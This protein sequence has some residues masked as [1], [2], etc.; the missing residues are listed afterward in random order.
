MDISAF[1]ALVSVIFAITF[2]VGLVVQT[3]AY[4][5]SL[6]T[7]RSDIVD[8]VWGMSFVFVGFF[9]IAFT[10]APSFSFA[11]ALLLVS[12]WGVRLSYHIGLRHF[13]K[14]TEDRRY[15]S[16]KEGWRF[17]QIRAYFQIFVLQAFLMSIIALPLVLH[18]NTG[19]TTALPLVCIGV[20]VWLLGFYFQVRGDFELSR[21]I[22]TKK[23]T[24]G[25]LKTGIWG[26]TRH[27]NYFGEMTMWWGIFI[28]T[29]SSFNLAY[30]I[31]AA[32][33]PILITL[34]LR[35]VSGVPMLEKYWE[36]KYQDEF[37]QY[38][39][40]VP[41]LIPDFRKFIGK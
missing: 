35:Y 18:A 29:I 20:L 12:V 11:V 4:V 32:L 26:L 28:V 7:K 40:N 31:V 21:Y 6:Y 23:K 9:W 39:E 17:P 30:L 13:S 24:D 1:L 25:L 3:S 14:E 8:V 34:L 10:Q 37:A 15:V 22:S 33:G 16:M 36:E 41:M 2:F 38:K 5:Y 27:P 19:V